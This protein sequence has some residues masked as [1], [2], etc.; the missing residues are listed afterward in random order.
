MKKKAAK[1]KAAPGRKAVKRKAP[2][3]KASLGRKAVKKKAAKK[4]HPKIS[5]TQKTPEQEVAPETS[6]ASGQAPGQADGEHPEPSGE[7]QDRDTL[8]HDD[9]NYLEDSQHDDPYHH[10]YEHEDHDTYH[11]HH[12][13]HYHHGH[14]EHQKEQ[15]DEHAVTVPVPR[16]GGSDGSDDGGPTELDENGEEYGGPVKSFLEHMEDLRWVL[17]RCVAA[18]AVAMVACLAAAPLLVET[19]ARPLGQAKE[20]LTENRMETL[21]EE[22]KS[23]I[24]VRLTEEEVF[25]IPV[26][27]NLLA[28]AYKLLDLN[29]EVTTFNLIPAVED[30]KLQLL[31]Q[32]GTNTQ[33]ADDDLTQAGPELKSMGP[34]S[35]F[36]VA[37]QMAFYGGIM[38]SLPFILYFLGEFTFPALRKKERKYLI[39]AVIIGGGLFFC[40][41]AFCYFL[42]MQ[43]A[44]STAA[45]FANWLNFGADIWRAEDYITFVCKF[46]IGMGIAFELPVVILLLVKIGVLD[47]KKLSKFRMYWVV[48]N[49]ILASILTPPDL[50]TQVLMALPM[51]IFYECSILIAWIWYRRDKK[52]EAQLAKEEAEANKTP[53]DEP[54]K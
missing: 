54:E 31:L 40:G 9:P 43:I 19:L 48:I 32:P 26:E 28:E 41:A 2:K 23:E 39:T 8:Y 44:L 24:H 10:D 17:I 42:L 53:P 36:L 30:G 16:G 29:N 5:P 51:Q 50:V 33:A 18:L 11:A 34:L 46:M 13:D 22:G 15:H 27:T 6:D 35:G 47:Y 37:L 38:I 20:F 45:L 14:E 7:N 52:K 21:S 12:D 49:L 4:K 1:K 25:R 3:K